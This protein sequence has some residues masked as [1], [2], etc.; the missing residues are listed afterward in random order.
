MPLYMPSR[1]AAAF[2]GM[3]CLAL[4][5]RWAGRLY[6]RS[7]AYLMV[8]LI[9][10]QPNFLFF[11]AGIN[12]DMPLTAV[13][14]VTLAAAVW[15]VARQKGAWGWFGL[16]L[17]TALTIL[18]KAN[19]V[20]ALAYL[21]MAGLLQLAHSRQW[22]PTVRLG[23]AALAGLIPLWAMWLI[24]NSIRMKDTLGVSGSL[25]VRDVLLEGPRHLL[26]L[27]PF[28]DIIWRSFWLDWSVGDIAYGPT[29]VYA[30]G[31]GV[32][33]LGLGGWV[34]PRPDPA[35]PHPLRLLF[36]PLLGALAISVL[37]L[38]VKA[39]SAYREGWIVPEGRWWLPVWPALV[40]LM[41]LGWQQWWPAAWRARANGV[42]TAVPILLTGYLLLGYLPHVY[43]HA[44]QVRNIPATAAPVGWQYGDQLEL[45]AIE[46]ASPINLPF[47]K[48]TAVSLFWRVTSPPPPTHNFI[49]ASQLI[50]IQPD[51]W[52]PLIQHNSHP[53]LGGSVT[54]AWQPTELWR[55]T[56][57]FAPRSADLHLNGPTQTTLAVWVGDGQTMLPIH[58]AGEPIAH[59][60][61]L[62]AIL[63]PDLSR[64]RPHTSRL[65]APVR[66]G[67]IIDLVA[68]TH[69]GDELVLWWQSVA[70]TPHSYTVFVHLLDEAGQLVRQAD[71]VPNAGLSP[72]A[73]W[74]P[75]ELV[76]DVRSIAPSGVLAIGLYDSETGG[77][78]TAVD[79]ATGEPLLHD[80]LHIMP[81]E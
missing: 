26:L 38:A 28:R 47:D 59:P 80:T 19:G 11:S 61:L 21:G 67:G 75:G 33:L 16:G 8:G 46:P 56:L 31:L 66:F 51:Q 2:L 29:W 15:V 65:A 71:G 76:R 41:A 14:A 64:T 30:V 42:A 36:I 52:E 18:T 39:L 54:S 12:N 17:L 44:E 69:T 25:P 7:T 62:P 3:L 68:V 55:D 77:R 34:R 81:T 40:W 78:L 37:Y 27:I 70:A 58:H 6:G 4:F 32:V 23:T 13:S 48:P 60:F 45:V 72:T 1:I 10:F 9:A 50:A 53:G 79:T 63:R 24:L 49:I 57:V 43:P 22:W 35:L 5:Y 20:F 73:V 74:L